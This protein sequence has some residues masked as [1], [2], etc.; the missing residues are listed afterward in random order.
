MRKLLLTLLAAIL[1]IGSI[2][3]LT[4][5]SQQTEPE[6]QYYSK[7]TDNSWCNISL[8]KDANFYVINLNV[9]G[10]HDMVFS[11]IFS[12]GY[13][14]VDEEKNIVSFNDKSSGFVLSAKLNEDHSLVFTDAFDFLKDKA[15]SYEGPTKGKLTKPNG[16]YR[17]D[18]TLIFDP[19]GTFVCK[20]Q[21]ELVF[22]KGSWKMEKNIVILTEDS[23]GAE[24][25]LLATPDGNLISMSIPG[26]T[27][28]REYY[29]ERR[30]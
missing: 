12:W 23:M 2:S 13:Y 20:E 6:G 18:H 11:S 29:P 19:D 16:L 15:F 14:T 5:K 28:A 8:W 24:F 22:F 1:A 10:S 4:C 26:N 3:S 21:E 30:D 17:G 7:I 25:H 27:G 9:S